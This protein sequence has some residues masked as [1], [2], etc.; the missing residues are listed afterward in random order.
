MP[1][2]T[3]PA[4]DG[5]LP[6]QVLMLMPDKALAEMKALVR[7]KMRIGHPPMPKEEWDQL[8]N[9]ECQLHLEAVNRHFLGTRVKSLKYGK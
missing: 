7:Y 5:R 1:K 3:P 6:P 8:C 9:L 2:K 4:K